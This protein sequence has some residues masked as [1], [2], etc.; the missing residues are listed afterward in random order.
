MRRPSTPSRAAPAA[1]AR[2]VAEEAGAP[3]AAVGIVRPVSSPEERS[4]GWA[5]EARRAVSEVRSACRQPWPVAVAGSAAPIDGLRPAGHV[6]AGSPIGK[7]PRGD[8]PRSRAITPSSAAVLAAAV[9]AA[10]T[11][12]FGAAATPAARRG[13]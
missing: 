3:G 6:T 10:M 5:S 9:S 2:P 4:S 11:S 8:A 7:P 1:A 12:C 13:V